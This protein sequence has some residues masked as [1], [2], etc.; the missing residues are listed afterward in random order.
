M[1]GCWKSVCE[2]R[3]LEC[4]S[5]VLASCARWKVCWMVVRG[6]C[7][8]CARCNTLCNRRRHLGR[9]LQRSRV[10][11]YP[12]ASCG[13]LTRSPNHRIAALQRGAD[14][15]LDGGSARVSDPFVHVFQR[16]IV[17]EEKKIYADFLPPP[18]TIRRSTT[19]PLFDAPPALYLC[20]TL[21]LQRGCSRAKVHNTPRC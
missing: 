6:R 10:P 17:G 14:E 5:C 9:R 13:R 21:H 19:A 11:N 2:T 15:G 8:V 18:R 1:F 12:C 7:V 20:A 4:A 16:E 3:V